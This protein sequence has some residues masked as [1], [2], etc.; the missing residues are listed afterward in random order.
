MR[1]GLR[2]YGFSVWSMAAL[3]GAI[4]AG[5]AQQGSPPDSA[6]IGKQAVSVVLKHY[7]MNPGSLDS[8]T[9]QPLPRNGNWSVGKTSP[10]NCPQTKQPCIEVFYEIPAESVRCSW[11]VL[12]NEDGTDGTFLDEND[13]TERYLRR[14]VSQSEAK[15][16]IKS[17]KKPI[18]PPIA[19]MA[20]ASGAVVVE[21]QVGKSGAVEKVAL[22]S[23][24]SMEQ[25]ASTDA[26]KDWSFKPL[27]VGKRAV[28]YEVQLVFTFRTSGPPYASVEVAP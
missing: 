26:A 17:R 2:R 3:A 25:K 18:F 15:A 6:S 24:P 28:Q 1:E 10:A 5:S 12:L 19:V 9:G 22:V 8:K 20:H 23:G 27:M 13:D 21:V 16:L 7:A 4:T 11:V 14:R